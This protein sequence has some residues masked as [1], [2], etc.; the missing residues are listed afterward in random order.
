MFATVQLPGGGL[1]WD[2]SRLYVDGVITVGGEIGDYNHDGIVNAADYTVWRDSL[3]SATNLAADG[4][5]NGVIDAGDYDA[6]VA[7]FGG[8]LG[9]SGAV[10]SGSVPEPATAMLILLGGVMMLGRV[11]RLTFPSR[12]SCDYR[13][14]PSACAATRLLFYLCDCDGGL[15]PPLHACAAA[16]QETG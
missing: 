4:N 8:T 11:R 13:S 5:E 12:V 7:H 10:E 3:G 2:T 1:T 16:R 6:W 9:G 15:R 14:A